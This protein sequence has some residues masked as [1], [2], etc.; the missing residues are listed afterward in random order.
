MTYCCCCRWGREVLS[1]GG[2]KG[3]GEHEGGRRLEGGRRT[4]WGTRGGLQLAAS[5]WTRFTYRAI[6]GHSKEV[7]IENPLAA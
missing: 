7:I 2:G 4:R 3:N 5:P 6:I 1:V